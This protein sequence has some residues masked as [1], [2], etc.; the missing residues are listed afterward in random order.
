MV[1]AEAVDLNVLDNDHFV[2]ALVKEGV[3]DK[4]LDVDVVAL[5]EEEQ[6]LGVARRRVEEALAVGV[7]ADALEQGAHGAAHALQALLGLL[8]R[9]L[10]AVAGAAA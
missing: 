9:L 6:G 7:L 3:V 10:S 1:L 2:V 4:V 5:C 8:G